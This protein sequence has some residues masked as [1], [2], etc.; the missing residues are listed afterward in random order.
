MAET[1]Q[2]QRRKG[3]T[4]KQVAGL[5]RKPKRHTLSDP[6]M[7]GHFLRV[8]P[9]GPIVFVAVARD[10]YGKP[11]WATLGSTADLKIDEA[12]QR[13]RTAI[14]RIKDGLSAFEP[15]SPKPDGVAVVTAEW[16]KRHAQKAKLRSAPEYRRI[17]DKYILPHWGERAFEEIRRSDVAKLLDHVEDQHGTAQADAVLSVLR[18]VGSWHHDRSDDYVSPFAGRQTPR[19]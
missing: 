12:R 2:R 6:E 17:V 8:P 9:D 4:D 1:A 3:L 13:A 19:P 7:R 18:M 15:P 16:L 11:V 10:P 5:R 14:R